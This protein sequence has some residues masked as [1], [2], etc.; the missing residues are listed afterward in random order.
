MAYAHRFIDKCRQIAHTGSFTV[1]ELKRAEITIVKLVQ[2]EA[3]PQERRCLQAGK[4]LRKDSEIIALNARLD[5]Q[6]LLRVGGRLR[7][8][9]IPKEARH[10]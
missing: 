3:F 10:R 8:A 9:N 7:H 6:G 5:N 2:Q 4:T 1:T